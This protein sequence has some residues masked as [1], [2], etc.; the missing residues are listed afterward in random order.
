MRSSL[1]GTAAS[2]QQRS[3]SHQVFEDVLVE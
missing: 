3:Q 1:E 2:W